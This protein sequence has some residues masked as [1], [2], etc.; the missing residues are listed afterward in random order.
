MSSQRL[1]DEMQATDRVGDSQIYLFFYYTMEKLLQLLNEYLWQSGIVAI[2]Q[3]IEWGRDIFFENV[4]WFHAEEAEIISKKFWFIERLVNKDRINYYKVG[5]IVDTYKWSLREK[6]YVVSD[7]VV[8]SMLMI[9][10]IQDD[11][12]SFLISVLK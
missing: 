12:I 10:A 3:E 7:C 2:D 11:P 9:L 6:A 1:T 5:E 4:D 8:E